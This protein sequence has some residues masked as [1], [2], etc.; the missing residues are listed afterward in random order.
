MYV[1]LHLAQPHF[2]PPIRSVCCSVL[3]E[4]TGICADGVTV[5]PPTLHHHSTTGV[6]NRAAGAVT[7]AAS[8]VAVTS[9][10]PDDNSGTKNLH[11][12][13]EQHGAL[14]LKTNSVDCGGTVGG[15]PYT[16][17]AP[18]QRQPSTPCYARGTSA[19]GGGAYRRRC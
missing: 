12:H 18:A 3:E 1:L 19:G 4:T 10:H 15:A 14:D 16:A 5:L 7:E 6:D 11:A 17:R 2:R 13:N 9:N 8:A